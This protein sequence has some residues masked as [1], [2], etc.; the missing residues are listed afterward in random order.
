MIIYSER[1]GHSHYTFLKNLNL[2]Y[3]EQFYS[4]EAI[5]SGVKS[6]HLGAILTRSSSKQ[7]G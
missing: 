4:N 3:S 7:K 1:V 2:K 6:E 5:Y